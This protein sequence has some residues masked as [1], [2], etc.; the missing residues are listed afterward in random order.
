M[1]LQ[2]APGRI[3]NGV[4]GLGND[5]GEALRRLLRTALARIDVARNKA[6]TLFVPQGVRARPRGASED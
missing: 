6:P 4:E 5:A 2:A 1:G 3:K